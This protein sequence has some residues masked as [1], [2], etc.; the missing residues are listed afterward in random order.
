[1]S[2]YEKLLQ[3]AKNSNKNFSFDELCKLAELAGFEFIR[4]KGSHKMY[5]HNSI[6][7]GMNFQNCNGKAKPY[8]VKQLLNAIE[9]INKERGER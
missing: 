7:Q 8:Q 9:E 2:D 5:R 6:S 3:K 1:M 4:L